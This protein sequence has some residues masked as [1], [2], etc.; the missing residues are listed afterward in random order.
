MD[1]QRRHDIDTLR[2][3][4]FGLVILYHVGMYYVAGW[5][6]HLKSPH[7]AA[8]LQM[9]MR[10]LNLW[11]M[12]LVFIVSG[13]AFGFLARNRS[14]A[15]L[16]RE[17]SVRLLVPLVFAMAVVVPF[18]PYAQALAN[19]VVAPGFVDFLARYYTGGPWPADAFDGADPG[20]TWNHLWYLP[21]LWLYSMVVALLLPALRSRSGERMRCS[22]TGLR[23]LQLLLLPAVPLLVYSTT[24]WP[25][26]K[27]TH[28][29]IHDGWLHAVY[30]TLFL[31]GWWVATDEGFWRETVRMRWMTLGLAVTL[32]GLVITVRGTTAVSGG[33]AQVLR[34]IGDLYLW[35]ALLTILGWAR[36]KL[37]RPWPWLAR[38]RESVYPWYILHQTVIIVLLFWLAP[39]GLGP[40]LEP[41]MLVVLTVAG[42]WILTSLIRRS[43]WLRPLFGLSAPVPARCPLPDPKAHR[44]AQSA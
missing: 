18:Q 23:G 29:L 16:V 13:I 41:A 33:V 28:D 37:D 15:T 44:P 8:W 4:A 39:L 20:V 11:R 3:L 24:L 7:E 10:A 5:H 31:Y 26:F 34:W 17:R 21:Y 6:W 14:F 19:G 40:V 35:A 9:P 32:L 42:C 27:P 12:D 25:A 38:A 30:F 2:A 22:L 43:G 36:L 1:T